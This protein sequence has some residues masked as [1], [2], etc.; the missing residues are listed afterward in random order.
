MTTGKLL[1]FTEEAKDIFEGTHKTSTSLTRAPGPPSVGVRGSSSSFPYWP[2]GMDD[3]LTKLIKKESMDISLFE[4]DLLDTPPGFQSGMKFE[5]KVYDQVDYAHS[6]PR[7]IN[8][9]E[10]LAMDDSI[11][12]E[13]FDD[14]ED[15]QEEICLEKVQLKKAENTEDEVFLKLATLPTLSISETV[16]KK[17]EVK[18]EWAV[19]DNVHEPVH[20]FEAK[21]PKMACKFPYKLDPFQQR[22]ILHLENKE[23]VFVAAHTSAGKTTVAEYAIHL[24]EKHKSR[25]IYTSPIK[26]LSNQKFSDFRE[27]FGEVG[28]ITGD[29]Q[30][31]EKA[32]CLIMTT[33]ILR[34][35]LYHGSSVIPELEWVIFDEVHYLNDSERGVVWEEVFIMLPDHVNLIMLSATVSNP[36]E[37]AE[38]V[39]DIKKRK[40]HVISTPKR[41]VPLVHHLYTG[42]VGQSQEDMFPIVNEN[43][44]FL[45]RMYQKACDTK[46]ERESKTKSTTGPKGPK[47]MV[48]PKQEKNIYIGLLR[49]LEKLDLLPAV[50]FT[51]S[52]KRCNLHAETLMCIDLTTQKEKGEIDMFFKHCISKLKDE[53]KKLPQVVKMGRQLQNGLGVHH[54][55]ILPILKEVVEKLFARSLVKVLFATETFAMGVNMPAKTVV[56]DSIRKHDGV[57]FRDLQPSEYIQMA[58][59]AGRRG[60]DLTGTVIVLCKADVPEASALVKMMLGK[61]TKLESQFKLTYSM[62]LN[63]L[64]MKTL[65]VEDVMK[66]SFA[67]SGPQKKQKKFKELL[68]ETNDKLAAI[69]KL[70]CSLCNVDLREYIKRQEKA[71]KLK[72]EVMED[73]VKQAITQKLFNPG[74]I[75]VVS[76][77]DKPGQNIL[78][79][80]LSMD[81]DNN[82]KVLAIVER[83]TDNPK[84]S[85]PTSSLE[86]NKLFYP[87]ERQP[88]ILTVDFRDIRVI[89]NKALKLDSITILKECRIV[90]TLSHNPGRSTRDA[91]QELCYLCEANLSGFPSAN[92]VLKDINSATKAL[93]LD[94]IEKSFENFTCTKCPEISKHYKEL[95]SYIQLEEDRDYYNLK[96]SEESL[97]LHPEYQA[98]KQVLKT[99]GYIDKDETVQLK[100]SVAREMSNHELVITEL[101]VKSV[102]TDCENDEVAALLSCMVFQQKCDDSNMKLPNHLEKKINEMRHVFMDIA[103]E[104]AKQG[105]QDPEFV[106]QFNFYLVPVVLKWAKGTTFAEIMKDTDIDEGIIVRT[107]QRL[108]ELLKDVR[109]GANLVGDTKLAKKMEDASQQIKRD[110]VFAASLYTEG[111]EEA[112]DNRKP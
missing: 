49:H 3:P 111:R 71:V 94:E 110:I 101:L 31:N 93:E 84:E 92:I 109:N 68:C 79:T 80:L 108:S 33:E 96:L 20:D 30:K 35:M 73:K 97:A 77:K 6:Q 5:K 54:S 19:I 37:L 87:S 22:A 105:I 86:S 106:S 8:L 43:G 112:K 11:D 42:S 69:T 44:K 21:L 88:G 28:L 82:C 63:L 95:S 47:H 15:K 64:K 9:S 60:K 32:F 102:F 104:Q 55:G 59:R 99:L 48:H 14:L 52:R 27:R 46:K 100:G 39:G 26:A 74:R 65:R 98:R 7:K 38:W 4:E 66:R 51:F 40:I 83:T 53:D 45:E 75:L 34:S 58:G 50:C 89:G 10:V 61:P 90:H 13:M 103:L 70:D 16:E 67:E 2:G 41:P 12:L 56:F 62:I 25:V 29:I 81:K 36:A 57:E 1:G 78:C 18:Y 85:N 107:I 17:P 23:N 72:I 76:V 91:Y 24:C